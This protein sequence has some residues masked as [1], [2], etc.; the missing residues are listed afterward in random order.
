MM[1]IN[2]NDTD[3]TKYRINLLRGNKLIVTKDDIKSKNVP[4]I[5]SITI[6]SENYIKESKNFQQE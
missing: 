1:D 5:G 4:A 3:S 2:N 6:S